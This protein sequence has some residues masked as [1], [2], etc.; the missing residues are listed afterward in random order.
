[1]PG[2][3]HTI[4]RERHAKRLMHLFRAMGEDVAAELDRLGFLK[5]EKNPR[6]WR[7]GPASLS[8]IPDVL[9]P[10]DPAVLRAWREFDPNVIP[11]IIRRVYRTHTGEQ[12]VYRFHAVGSHRW[13][14]DTRPSP[15][16]AKIMLPS[17]TYMPR[18]THLDLH[19][20]DRSL[21][22]GNGLPG[23]YIPF[24]WRIYHGMR[25]L[26]QD[27]TAKE[28]IRWITE[29]DSAAKARTRRE[30]IEADRAQYA[31]SRE[32]QRFIKNHMDKIDKDDV[33]RLMRN[34]YE[35]KRA[36]TVSVP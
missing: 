13:N 9:Y 30:K 35:P 15:T 6:P 16:L 5:P 31:A 25:A 20:E 3:A 14:P 36:I 18:P 34:V 23:E 17:S 26:W 21:R 2:R 10:H 11:L 33:K 29:N 27:W 4:T 22:P 32:Q 8:A 24:D 28:K 1:M 7:P 19:F 12:R